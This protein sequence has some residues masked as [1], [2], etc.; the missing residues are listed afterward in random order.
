MKFL[1]HSSHCYQRQ[2]YSQVSL[3]YT[4]RPIFRKPLQRKKKPRI[5][6]LEQQTNLVSFFLAKETI[7]SEF[8]WIFV[9]QWWQVEQGVTCKFLAVWKRTRVRDIDG[10]WREKNGQR[11]IPRFDLRPSLLQRGQWSTVLPGPT[12]ACFYRNAPSPSSSCC[13][14]CPGPTVQ[15]VRFTPWHAKAHPSSLV[16]LTSVRSSETR[17]VLKF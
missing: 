13:L 6:L 7:S 8:C 4:E 10:I 14:L 3:R 15:N 16:N 9:L 12:R 1:I 5:I 11:C 17:F 2:I